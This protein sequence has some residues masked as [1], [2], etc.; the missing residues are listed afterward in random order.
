MKLSAMLYKKFAKSSGTIIKNGGNT[1][2]N[3]LQ[4]TLVD[5]KALETKRH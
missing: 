1:A 4:A 2:V 5:L 3:S